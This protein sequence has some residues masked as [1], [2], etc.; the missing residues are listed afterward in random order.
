MIKNK[1]RVSFLID[2]IEGLEIKDEKGGIYT[3][4]VE[5]VDFPNKGNVIVKTEEDGQTIEERAV[6]KN[7]IPGQTVKFMV[8]KKKHGKCEGR[9]LE[10][11][12]QA[13]TETN[14]RCEHFGKCGGCV[15]Q[16][17]KYEEQ[18]KMKENAVKK[19]LAP[20]INTEYEWEGI[21]GSP[22]SSEYRNKMEFSFGD[23]VKDG[24][25]ALGL[26][27]RNSMY[28]IVTV[29]GCKIV[30]NDYRKYSSVYMIM[31]LRKSHLLPQ[32]EARGVS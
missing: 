31:H 3:G 7:S 13:D 6:V 29:T 10:V 9:L 5:S 17:V 2:Y 23:E 20:V 32:N 19:L 26:H 30:D 4:Y 22:V 14:E 25:I 21:I 8:N 18:L 24:P 16:T 12:C 11:V 15:Y 27:K 28:D 1:D